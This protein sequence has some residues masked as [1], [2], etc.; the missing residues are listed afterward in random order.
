MNTFE[1]NH[2]LEAQKLRRAEANFEKLINEFYSFF[3]PE[4]I[5]KI[6]Q[7][8]EEV[9]SDD[10]LEQF[11]LEGLIDYYEDEDEEIAEGL[12]GHC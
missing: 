5:N 1:L 4:Q 8:E 9:N 6:K 12:L 3:K 11:N 2:N 7:E 10:E